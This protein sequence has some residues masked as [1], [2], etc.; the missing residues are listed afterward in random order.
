MGSHGKQNDMQHAAADEE[1]RYYL[2]YPHHPQR[3]E[4]RL[5]AGFGHVGER[6]DWGGMYVTMFS[7][8][9]AY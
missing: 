4:R 7:F 6:D 3:L 5:S 2:S 8:F 9:C 1:Y